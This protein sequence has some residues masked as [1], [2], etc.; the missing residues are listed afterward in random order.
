VKGERKRAEG[1]R[2]KGQRIGKRKR[3]RA[4]GREPRA[5]IRKEEIENSEW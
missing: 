3:K 5:G 2:V 1:K 4:E